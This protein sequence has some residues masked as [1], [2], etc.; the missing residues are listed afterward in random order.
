MNLLL[1]RQPLVRL[2]LPVFRRISLVDIIFKL[3]IVRFKKAFNIRDAIL[4]ILRLYKKFK[5]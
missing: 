3:K 4:K 2:T 1:A 5:I